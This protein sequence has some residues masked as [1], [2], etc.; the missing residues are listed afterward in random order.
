[1]SSRLRADATAAGVLQPELRE[2]GEAAAGEGEMS[3]RST[4]FRE[5]GL[6]LRGLA[7]NFSEL[8]N[9]MDV[10]LECAEAI[11]EYGKLVLTIN[12]NGSGSC[13]ELSSFLIK[14]KID[15]CSGLP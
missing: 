6:M 9:G 7:L 10:A 11:E 5:A 14:P 15:Y 3:V 13:Q 12:K 2:D 1:M 4:A 8:P